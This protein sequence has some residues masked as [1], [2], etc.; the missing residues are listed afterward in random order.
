M[1]TF[2]PRRVDSRCPHAVVG[3]AVHQDDSPFILNENWYL[4]GY[5]PNDLFIKVTNG[6]DRITII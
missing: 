3:T 5:W 1:S 2:A 4:E 6:P